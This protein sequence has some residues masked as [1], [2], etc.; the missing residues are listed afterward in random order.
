MR[1]AH[2]HLTV[3]A[4]S[5]VPKAKSEFF[6]LNTGKIELEV[7]R[8]PCVSIAYLENIENLDDLSYVFNSSKLVNPKEF[9]RKVFLENAEQLFKSGDLNGIFNNITLETGMKLNITTWEQ[10]ENLCNSPSFEKSTLFN[11]VR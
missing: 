6:D 1:S 4:K 2:D 5:Q 10:L 11:F 3:P 8:K 7:A 9:M